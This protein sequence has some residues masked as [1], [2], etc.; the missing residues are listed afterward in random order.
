M[1]WKVWI[2]ALGNR[3]ERAGDETKQRRLAAGH[4]RL[5]QRAD[6]E[7]IHFK[8]AVGQPLAIERRE[9][10]EP[11]EVHV[12]EI[13]GDRVLDVGSVEDAKLAVER[14]AGREELQAPELLDELPLAIEDDEGAFAAHGALQILRD[15]ILQR[16]R[17]ARAGAGDDPVVRV[18]RALPGWRR[19]AA[20]REFPQTACRR[21]RARDRRGG[22]ARRVSAAWRTWRAERRR[23]GTCCRDI[24]RRR[25][26]TAARRA[27]ARGLRRSVRV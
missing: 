19:R 24:A 20:W 22:A 25:R 1:S 14:L 18:V 9:R 13:E 2:V 26:G 12:E 11:I 6:D 23:C 4:F 21:E 10:R 27:V 3:E 15:E 8:R 7:V 17:L 5:Q 16:G